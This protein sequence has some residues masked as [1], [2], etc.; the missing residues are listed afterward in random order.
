MEYAYSFMMIAF[1]AMMLL[2]A[3]L[4]AL[5]KDYKMIPRHWYVRPKDPK[6]YAVCFAKLIAVI[7]LGP[8]VSGGIWAIAPTTLWVQ[9]LAIAILVLSI[10]VDVKVGKKLFGPIFNDTGI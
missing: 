2:Y 5:F 10:V 9:I 6:H 4:L 8:I 1:G 3:G 7:A